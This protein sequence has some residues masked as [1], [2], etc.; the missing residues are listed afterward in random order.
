MLLCAGRPGNPFSDEHSA[1]V[2]VKSMTFLWIFR[3]VGSLVIVHCFLGFA[4]LWS[5]SIEQQA[6]QF[7]ILAIASYFSSMFVSASLSSFFEEW[8]VTRWLAWPAFVSIWFIMV[9]IVYMI[10]VSMQ[11]ESNVPV[12]AFRVYAVCQIL[13]L[14]ETLF[15]PIVD[16]TSWRDV[17]FSKHQF[18][19]T[20]RQ[21]SD[22]I[23]NP[24]GKQSA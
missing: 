2:P 22:E 23:I 1:Q 21:E 15:G 6:V 10:L 18:A 11:E 20:N 4:L 14:P 8:S 12:F 13:M 7:A 17:R 19:A 5:C 3:P 24:F 16:R 9:A